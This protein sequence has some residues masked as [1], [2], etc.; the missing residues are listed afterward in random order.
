MCYIIYKTINQVNG[1]IYVGQHYQDTSA[2][3]GYLGS[4]KYLKKAMKK[5]GKDNFIRETL[6]L[7]TSSNV[8]ER[9]IFYI[10]NLSAINQNIGYNIAIGGF[11]PPNQ[12]GYKHTDETIN[13]IRNASIGRDF[14]NRKP[15]TI[16]T[17]LKRSESM[18][19]KNTQKRSIEARLKMSKSKKGK[20][21]HII[22]DVLRKQISISKSNYIWCF[23]DPNNII[24]DNINSCKYFC[25]EHGLNNYSLYNSLKKRNG[26][27][28]G[29]LVTRRIKD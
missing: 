3:D 21:G 24:Y 26:H 23:V 9:E 11:R 18:K 8:D 19:G 5:Y 1:K 10:S 2:F 14:S 29:W 6:E 22:S 17:R 16:E 27:Y 7:C 4:G 12:I 13:K 20:P 25:I 28:K 15:V